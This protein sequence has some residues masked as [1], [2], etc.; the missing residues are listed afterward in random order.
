MD[1]KGFLREKRAAVLKRWLD[2]VLMT[3][4]QQTAEFLKNRKNQF[5]N[6][7]GQI[8]TDG[9][10][11]IF[12][13]LIADLGPGGR[14]GEGADAGNLAEFLDNIVKV[15]AIQDFSASEAVGFIFSLKKAV[16]AELGALGDDGAELYAELDGFD[17]SVD[18]LALAA[19]DAYA[20]C[21][22][23]IFELKTSEFRNQ[24]FR[25]F[26]QAHLIVDTPEGGENDENPEDKIG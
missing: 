6:P 21:R 4:P 14:S 10:S 2:Y 19:F 13:V 17:D 7:V 26:Q 12:D 15:R 16:R 1:L 25:L 11:G 18:R 5:A 20:R 22:E 23:R 9:I 24:A 8:I 3:Y